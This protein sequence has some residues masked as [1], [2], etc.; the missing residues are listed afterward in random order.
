MWIAAVFGFFVWST[1]THT[2]RARQLYRG[3]V[4]ADHHII[5]VFCCRLPYY[6]LACFVTFCKFLHISWCCSAR[7]C[8]TCFGRSDAPLIRCRHKP[9]HS[10]CM[11][12]HVLSTLL[13][14]FSRYTFSRSKWFLAGFFSLS[15]S[16]SVLRSLVYGVPWFRTSNTNTNTSA[17]Y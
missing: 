5:V 9:Y 16:L 17:H 1:H 3:K 2:Q 13:A 12:S 11:I 15:L 6:S 14:R 4:R 10:N 8:L 7:S